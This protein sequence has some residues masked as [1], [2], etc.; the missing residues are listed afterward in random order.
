MIGFGALV[1][2]LITAYG[3]VINP[4]FALPIIGHFVVYEFLAEFIA[5]LTGIGIVTL[6]GIRQVTRFRMLNRDS[7]S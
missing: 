7:V 1:G 5:A 3:Q 4:E 2:T 6:I